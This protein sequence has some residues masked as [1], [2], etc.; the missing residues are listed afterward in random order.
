MNVDECNVNLSTL[1]VSALFSFP[2]FIYQN[3]HIKNCLVFTILSLFTRTVYEF[4]IKHIQWRIEAFGE[5]CI[6]VVLKCLECIECTRIS[7]AI[8]KLDIAY[9]FLLIHSVQYIMMRLQSS[10]KFSQN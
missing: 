6:P 1:K 8:H 9:N 2:Y 3:I 7:Y 5:A 10:F 4:Q